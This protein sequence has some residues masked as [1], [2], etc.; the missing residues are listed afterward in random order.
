MYAG[1]EKIIFFPR[2]QPG[3]KYFLQGN[4]MVIMTFFEKKS[5]QEFSEAIGNNSELKY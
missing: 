1:Q 3:D 4:S 2:A 5:C